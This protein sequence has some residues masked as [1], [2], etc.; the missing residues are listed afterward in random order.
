MR[1]WLSIFPT[2]IT[3]MSERTEAIASYFFCSRRENGRTEE[4]PVYPQ[5]YISTYVWA[6]QS[7]VHM[8][9]SFPSFLVGKNFSDKTENRQYLGWRSFPPATADMK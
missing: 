8:D 5:R 1:H 2:V 3:A 4:G 6:E 7:A 9:S